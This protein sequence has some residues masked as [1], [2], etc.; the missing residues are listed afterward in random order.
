MEFQSH[1]MAADVD[2][3]A[4]AVCFRVAVH[5]IR[6][7]S[8]KPPGLHLFDS[9]LHTFLRHLHQPEIFLLHI[10]NAEHTGGIPV[11]PVIDGRNIHI[12]DVAVLQHIRFAGNTVADLAVDGG[13]DALR[14]A[15]IS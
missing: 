4:V 7:I 5:R 2:D 14:E 3:H 9:L 1:S 13:A 12:D 6:H 15:L 11:I 10:S 8:Q